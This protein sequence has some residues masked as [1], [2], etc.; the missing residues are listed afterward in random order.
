MSVRM[1]T[2]LPSPT[3]CLCSVRVHKIRISGD[4]G[5]ANAGD[6]AVVGDISVSLNS[7]SPHQLTLAAAGHGGIYDSCIPIVDGPSTN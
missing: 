2:S 5:N 4:N 1:E 6:R 3:V 7:N